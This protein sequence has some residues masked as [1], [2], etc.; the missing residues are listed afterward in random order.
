MTAEAGHSVDQAGRAS[1]EA[2]LQVVRELAVELHPKRARSL[3]VTLDST[4]DRGLGFD[5][6]SRAELLLRLER[7]FGDSLPDR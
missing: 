1:A 4:L 6:L 2:L 7:S 5:S 3:R